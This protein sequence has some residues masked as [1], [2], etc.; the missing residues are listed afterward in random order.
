MLSSAQSPIT[1]TYEADLSLRSMGSRTS[2]GVGGV[3]DILAY[4]FRAELLPYLSDAA[5][6]AAPKEPVPSPTLHGSKEVA[7]STWAYEYLDA[8]S[9]ATS[10]PVVELVSLI[11]NR[12]GRRVLEAYVPMRPYQW[13]GFAERIT[14][15][16]ARVAKVDKR[17][18]SVS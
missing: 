1:I 3:L 9:R 6:L 13:S 15:A 14:A 10:V 8:I 12:G 18:G 7:M 16:A 17:K 5:L 11:V 2:L 4:A